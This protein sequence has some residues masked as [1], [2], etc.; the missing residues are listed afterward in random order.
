MGG[1]DDAG[2]VFGQRHRHLEAHS[3]RGSGEESRLAGEVEEVGHRLHI[4]VER[5]VEASD[6]EP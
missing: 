6:G 1:H 4:P 3:P 2:A 5:R